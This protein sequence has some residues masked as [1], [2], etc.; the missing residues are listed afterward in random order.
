MKRK[1]KV[2]EQKRFGEKTNRIGFEL[3]NSKL[4]TFLRDFCNT[5]DLTRDFSFFFH[6]ISIFLKKLE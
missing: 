5:R 4:F 1:E 6:N 2:I 3:K